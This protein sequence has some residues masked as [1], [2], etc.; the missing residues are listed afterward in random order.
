LNT[1]KKNLSISLL[2]LMLTACGGGGGGA[3]GPINNFVNE[4]LST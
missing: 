4:D 1:F 3:T 2:P